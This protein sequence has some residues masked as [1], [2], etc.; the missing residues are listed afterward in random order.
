MLVFCRG[1]WMYEVINPFQSSVAFHIKTSNLFC[2][3]KQMTGF[4]MKRNTGLK[5]V[6]SLKIFFSV[7]VGILCLKTL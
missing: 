7:E 1:C 4:Y 6:K 3:G 2:F 5:W